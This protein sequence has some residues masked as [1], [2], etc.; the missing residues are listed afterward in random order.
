[1]QTIT[2]EHLEMRLEDSSR[3]VLVDF[4]ATWCRPCRVM[5][6]SLAVLEGEFGGRIDFVKVD[7]DG[8]ERTVR[9]FAIWGVPT[10]VLHDRGRTVDS[11]SGVLSPA[12]LREWIE[13]RL[14]AGSGS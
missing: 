8:A 10:L 4:F 12:A 2:E 7:I 1:M 13:R 11:V 5:E 3:P 14:P 6:Q 9:K